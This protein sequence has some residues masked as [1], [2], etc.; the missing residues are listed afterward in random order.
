M[1]QVEPSDC[2]ATTTVPLE[3]A[4]KAIREAE[5]GDAIH[6]LISFIPDEL[7]ALIFE[8]YV[9]FKLTMVEELLR[10]NFLL[11]CR[12]WKDIAYHFHRI[13][14]KMA[15]FLKEDDPVTNSEAVTM[16]LSRILAISKHSNG[17]LVDFSL[18]L[19]RP[20]LQALNDAMIHALVQHPIRFRSFAEVSGKEIQ[21]PGW[22][23]L[24]SQIQSSTYTELTRL[25]ITGDMHGD[26]ESMRITEPVLL[27]KLRILQIQRSCWLATLFYLQCPELRELTIST[28]ELLWDP[29]E[30]TEEP[31]WEEFVELL[32]GFP[33]L[34][35][36]IYVLYGPLNSIFSR[37]ELSGG[38]THPA[39]KRVAFIS[40]DLA[41]DDWPVQHFFDAFPN[42]QDLTVSAWTFRMDTVAPFQSLTDLYI[43]PSISTWQIAKLENDDYWENIVQGYS[44]LICSLPELTELTFAIELEFIVESEWPFTLLRWPRDMTLMSRYVTHRFFTCIADILSDFKDDDGNHIQYCPKLR[45]LRLFNVFISVAAVKVMFRN[46]RVDP[47]S[48]LFTAVGC[49]YET[50]SFLTLEEQVENPRQEIVFLLDMFDEIPLPKAIRQ[51]SKV[52][53]HIWQTGR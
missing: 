18:T 8:L 48:C 17:L 32:S 10:F 21:F 40:L 27:P 16:I 22:L 51:L 7:L 19:E 35:T 14:T 5:G 45:H 30:T 53:K 43:R 47:D 44:R 2:S 20:V 34:E 39:V 6:S 29:G 25:H 37:P 4:S 15:I 52:F 23:I 49:M 50:N 42:L 41:Y 24:D 31:S 1:L 26:L 33:L 9:G 13:W 11:V 28:S 38:V 3:N 12:S 36:F 46:S